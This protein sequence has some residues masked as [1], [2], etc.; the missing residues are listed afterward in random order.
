VRV[1]PLRAAIMVEFL[2]FHRRLP[3]LD[4]PR[5]FCE[6]IAQRKLYDRNPLL[7]E[8]SDKIRAKEYVARELG[9][10]WVIPNL[11]SGSQLPP[12]EERRWPIPYLLKA[13]HGSSWN[14]FVLSKAE[15]DWDAIEAKASKW[16]SKTY[17]QHAVEWLYTQIR[18]G[19]IVEPFL[20]ANG[21]APADYKFFVF[22]GRTVYIQVDLGRLQTHRQLFYDVHWKRQKFE[23]ICPWTDEEAERPESLAAMIEAANH[24][25]AP[26]PFARVDLYEIDGKP[27]FGEMTFYPNSGRYAFKPESAE[28]EMGRLWPDVPVSEP[29]AQFELAKGTLR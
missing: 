12:R 20:G 1:L 17:G 11:W 18:P 9:S 6:K 2:Y 25:G 14:C 13:N 23:Y 26:F 4:Q 15:E 22:G 10:D 8:L 16:L 21:I 5:T 24:L 28:R 3:R 29:G 19:L 7:P 27:R